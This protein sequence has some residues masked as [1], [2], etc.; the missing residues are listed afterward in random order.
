MQGLDL[1][2][3][4]YLVKP[5]DL[6]EL[7]ARLRALLRREARQPS[8]TLRHGAV[9]L[10]VTAKRA[11]RD[12]RPVTLTAREFAALHALMHRPRHIVS[13]AQLKE[14]LD[15][16]GEK[17]ESNAIEVHIYNLRRKFGHGFITAVRHQGY[18]L[19]PA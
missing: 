8:T 16:W 15:G 5:F 9:A 17:V 11:T 12:G 2:A 18:G 13:R 3:E 6:E 10:D 19:V 1:G 14:A 4:D 7:S